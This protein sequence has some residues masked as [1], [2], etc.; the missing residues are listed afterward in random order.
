VNDHL[1]KHLVL[2]IL[3]DRGSV[4]VFADGGLVAMSIAAIPDEKNRKVELHAEG[5][6]INILQMN[7]HRMQSAW[8][9]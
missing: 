5:D 2:R 3:V 4:E 1:P 9:K 8:E 7:I 6:A